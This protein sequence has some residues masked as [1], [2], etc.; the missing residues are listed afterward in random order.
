MN[1]RYVLTTVKLK[2]LLSHKVQTQ[3]L[4]FTFTWNVKRP[5][6]NFVPIFNSKV[7]VRLIHECDLYS[8]KYGIYIY[9]YIYLCE[10]SLQL[11]TN[12][13]PDVNFYWMS[14]VF[15]FHIFINHHSV[16]I[17]IVLGVKRSMVKVTHRSW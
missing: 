12:L 11:C 6:N 5:Q 17:P 16:K 15:K 9:I 4:L 7:G 14:V 8:S 1:Q 10:S 3:N 2:D 13:F